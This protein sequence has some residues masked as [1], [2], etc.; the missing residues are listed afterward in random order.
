M[1]KSEKKEN[2]ER[3]KREIKD[4]V[5]RILSEIAGNPNEAILRGASFQLHALMQKAASLNLYVAG[6]AEA[7]NMIANRT[8]QNVIGVINNTKEEEEI[9]KLKVVEDRIESVM[10][11]AYIHTLTMDKISKEL[12]TNECCTAIISFM[13]NLLET[14]EHNSSP[15]HFEKYKDEE[16]KKLVNIF[17]QDTIQ[18]VMNKSYQIK[19]HRDH[20]EEKA[21]ELAK[22]SSEVTK[23]DSPFADKLKE[24]SDN[25]KK[26]LNEIVSTSYEQTKMVDMFGKMCW[27]D[28]MHVH[29]VNTDKT[30]LSNQSNEKSNTTPQE[31]SWTEL[32]TEKPV[33]NKSIFSMEAVVEN[34]TSRTFTPNPTPKID[35]NKPNSPKR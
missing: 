5:A 20:I 22:I 1:D 21:K 24:I 14:K 17:G 15:E 16:L 26:H 29:T 25:G 3:V 4:E 13:K 19:I 8:H 10:E 23:I 28:S 32:K 30:E 7:S 2:R 35:N 31:Q 6:L 34:N 11:D 12:A 18:S 9:K 33:G 27:G